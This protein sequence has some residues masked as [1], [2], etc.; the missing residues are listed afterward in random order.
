MKASG[1]KSKQ[2]S[3]S[4]SFTSRTRGHSASQSDNRC[5]IGPEITIDQNKL[6]IFLKW[7]HIKATSLHAR[8]NKTAVRRVHEARSVS[9]YLLQRLG[10]EAVRLSCFSHHRTVSRRE[11]LEAWDQMRRH[12]NPAPLAG[13]WVFLTDVF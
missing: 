8:V 2:C 13:A 6:K 1:F 11:I 3:S 9:R 5:F 4:R 7:L 12:R 10:S